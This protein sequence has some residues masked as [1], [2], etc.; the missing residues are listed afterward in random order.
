MAKTHRDIIFHTLNDF[1][2]SDGGTIRIKALVDGFSRHQNIEVRTCVGSQFSCSDGAK[3]NVERV[4]PYLTKNQKK[5]LVLCTAIFPS[6][7]VST[8]Y[9]TLN[10]KLPRF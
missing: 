10:K 9:H 6:R 4:Y 2:L 1:S 3:V 7:V 5:L 8:L